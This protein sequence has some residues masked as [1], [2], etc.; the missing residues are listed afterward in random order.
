MRE[1]WHGLGFDMR[2]CLVIRKPMDAT[3]VSDDSDVPDIPCGM[4]STANLLSALHFVFMF[5]VSQIIMYKYFATPRS[6]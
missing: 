6:Q 5:F 2:R 3:G 1:I 4:K